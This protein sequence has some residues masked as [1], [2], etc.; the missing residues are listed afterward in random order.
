MMTENN[1]YKQLIKS[2]PKPSYCVAY[3]TGCTFLKLIIMNYKFRAYNTKEKK[4]EFGYDYPN[5]G[6]FSLTG[7]VV[8]MGELNSVSLD[9][10]FNDLVFMQFTGLKDKNGKEIYTGDVLCD[11]RL[12]GTYRMYK[13]FNGKG[14]FV[15][16]THSD[17]FKKPVNKILFTEACADMQNAGFLENCEIE[18]NYIVNPELYTDATV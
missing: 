8:L 14:G 12:D 17:D 6:G 13:I 18:G 3:V 15:F 1:K 5:L 2:N 16:N 4:W 10:L 11:Y 7:E 9:T